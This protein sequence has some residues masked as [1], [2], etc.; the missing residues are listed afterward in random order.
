MH[1]RVARHQ[2]F[3]VA[4]RL[5]VAGAGSD[6][7]DVPEIAFL[8][9]MLERIAVHL[10]GRGVHQRR[11]GAAGEIE[12][13]ARARRSDLEGLEGHP[14]VVHRRG[15]RGHVED[16][17]GRAGD[18]N[19]LADVVLDQPETIVAREMVEVLLAPREEAVDHHHLHALAQE[20]VGEMAADEPS[21]SEDDGPDHFVRP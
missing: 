5:V 1:P 3:G 6:G 20:P 2:G 14:R 7:I 10:A 9:R 4:L 19:R 12:G 21:A 8:L 18:G 15:R 13:V 17:L 11:T 16:H